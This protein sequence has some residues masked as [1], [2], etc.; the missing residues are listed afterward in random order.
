VSSGKNAFSLLWVVYWMDHHLAKVVGAETPCGILAG[1]NSDK[2]LSR[3][4]RFPW[5]SF[6]KLYL[7]IFF[8][9]MLFRISAL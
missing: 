7:C 9:G 8:T 1:R 2:R 5:P 3:S 6:S 4:F